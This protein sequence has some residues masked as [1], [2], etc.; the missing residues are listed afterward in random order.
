VDVDRELRTEL[1][2]GV[3]PR[4]TGVRAIALYKAVKAAAFLIVGT[5]LGALLA[6]GHI[7]WAHELAVT[8]RDHVVHKWSIRLAELLLQWLTAKRLWWLVAALV[9]DA[10]I[11]SIEALAL[12]RG[13]RWAAWFVVAVTS[14]LLPVEVI[15]LAERLTLGRVLIFAINLA[16]VL[17]L[18]RRAMKEH[19]ALHL[20][21]RRLRREM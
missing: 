2:E 8:L 20:A 3:S 12:A 19:H 18:L 11:S 6:T 10:I 17:Y 1:G 21:P 5:V 7:G 9:G 13:Y 15:E 14:L 16:I 4:A